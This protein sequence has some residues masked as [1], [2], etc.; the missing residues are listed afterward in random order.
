MK[1]NICKIGLNTNNRK[2]IQQP[3]E[4]VGTRDEIT[5]VRNENFPYHNY[6]ST[7]VVR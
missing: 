4:T 2:N 7:V 6:R 5:I 3:L 1:K